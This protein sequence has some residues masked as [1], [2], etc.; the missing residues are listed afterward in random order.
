MTGPNIRPTRLYIALAL[1]AG[2]VVVTPPKVTNTMLRDLSLELTVEGG[3]GGG[4]NWSY[5]GAV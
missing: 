4:G 1:L 3:E 5:G 2:L